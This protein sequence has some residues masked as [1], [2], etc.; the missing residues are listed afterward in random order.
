MP[1]LP[2]AGVS[3]GTGVATGEEARQAAE[4]QYREFLMF[5]EQQSEHVATKLTLDGRI[6]ILERDNA[7]YM[8]QLGELQQESNRYGYG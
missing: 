6:Q 1:P 4:K 5:V 7:L 3:G 2:F 8:R